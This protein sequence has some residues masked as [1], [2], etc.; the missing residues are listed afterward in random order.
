MIYEEDENV[1]MILSSIAIHTWSEDE[2]D[3]FASN[4]P[5]KYHS[6]WYRSEANPGMGILVF[7]DEVYAKKFDIFM[8][9]G[10]IKSKVVVFE[11]EE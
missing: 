10:G 3:W 7:E 8:K 5:T 6:K 4:V 11:G 2:I 1:N 9:R